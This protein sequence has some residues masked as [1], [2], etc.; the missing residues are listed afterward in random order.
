[1]KILETYVL[2]APGVSGIEDAKHQL[3]NAV[4]DR[5]VRARREGCVLDAKSLHEMRSKKRGDEP[6]DLPSDVELSA[7]DAEAI[8][9]E[10]T[11]AALKVYVED[12]LTV[13]QRIIERLGKREIGGE[14]IAF[15][16]YEEQWRRYSNL[17]GTQI[18]KIRDRHVWDTLRG[19]L[20]ELQE[21]FDHVLSSVAHGTKESEDIPAEKIKSKRGRRKGTGS[22]EKYDKP[23]VEEMHK[24]YTTEEAPSPHAA[25]VNLVGKAYGAA[26][27]ESKIRR[28]CDRYKARYG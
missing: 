22:Y 23:L 24:L 13:L 10:S 3:Y 12:K 15:H 20:N 16:Q 11:D 14:F 28:L 17:A 5:E 6:Y 7:V 19:R 8:W 4:I 18:A 26:T 9:P 21:Q 2:G 1:L 25:A 27:D